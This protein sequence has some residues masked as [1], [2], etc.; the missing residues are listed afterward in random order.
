MEATVPGTLLGRRLDR[1]KS[2]SPRPPPDGGRR[3][4]DH[5]VALAE[6]VGGQVVRGEFGPIV[7]IETST[8]VAIAVDRLARLPYSIDTQAPLVFVDLETTGL[9]TAAGTLPFLVGAAI[10]QDGQ[11]RMSQLLLPDHASERAM[12]DVL[13]ALL[14]TDGW[15]V[16]YN[17]K[18]FDWPLLTARYRLHRRDATRARQATSICCRSPAS[19]GSTVSAAPGW[20]SSSR[21]CAASSAMTICPGHLIPERYFSYLRSRRPDLLTP[22][23]QHNRQDIVSMARLV[24]VLADS[25]AD[26]DAWADAHPGDLHGLARG[27]VRRRRH[28]EA[29]TVVEAALGARAWTIG[30]EGGAGLHRRLSADRAWL[31]ARLGRRDE[32]YAAWTEIAARA[33]PGAGVAWLHVARYREHVLRDVGGALVACQQAGAVAERARAWGDPLYAV[34]ADLARRLPR[35]RRL[36]FRRRPLRGA[37]GHAA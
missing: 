34:E 9:A 37:V 3:L 29:L 18:C 22:I 2:G 33:G 31:L 24:A 12:L 35:L 5:A 27:F 19:C 11:L 30:V 20:H 25:L 7:T 28:D 36:S 1:L 21:S 15:L 16:T 8:P 13:L 17:G 6:A 32:S 23:V 4:D 26:S 10:W 14:P